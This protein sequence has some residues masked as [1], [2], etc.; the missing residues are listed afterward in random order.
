MIA[1]YLTA[2]YVAGK[3]QN[4]ICRISL[5]FGE[6]GRCRHHEP[7]EANSESHWVEIGSRQR[8]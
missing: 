1:G 6:T 8:W 4:V 2:R 5:T 3:R 7:R